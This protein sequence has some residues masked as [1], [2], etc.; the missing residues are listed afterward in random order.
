MKTFSSAV[1]FLAGL[2]A[3]SPVQQQTR[4]SVGPYQI[5]EF[6]ASKRH[7][8]GYCDFAFDVSAPGL[9]GAAHCTA[10]LDAG[11]SGATWLANVYEGA[12]KCDDSAVTWTF[13]QSHAEGSGASLNVTVNGVKGLR[14]IPPED[15]SVRLN[16]EANPFDNDVAYAGPKAF[17]IT[18]FEETE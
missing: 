4:Q 7:N 6:S 3:A 8:S 2:A 1:L 10:S 12:G 18:E 17:E 11:F 13:F 16:D 15:I 14:D 5:A 9:E